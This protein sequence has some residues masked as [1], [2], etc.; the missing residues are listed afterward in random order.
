MAMEEN[1]AAKKIRLRAIQYAK[2]HKKT[3]AKEFT[4]VEVYLPEDNPVSVFMAGSPGAGKTEASKELLNDTLAGS[5]RMVLR[6]DLD[7]LRE[8][9]P[10]YDGTNAWLFQYPASILVDRI[11]DLALKQSQSFLLDGTLAKYDRAERNIRRSLNK[12]RRVQILYVYQ[13]PGLAWEFVK[14][15][16]A[17]EGRRV[18]PERFVDQYFGARETVNQLKMTFGERIRVDLLLKNTDGSDK[19]YENGI[20]QIDYHIPENY[21]RSQVSTLVGLE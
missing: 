11:H 13:K 7:E 14:A 2:K 17:K 9:F 5:D 1:S 19:I 21:D 4:N 20:D 3:I 15:R 10:D 12:G 6:I 8:R 18:P 16:E